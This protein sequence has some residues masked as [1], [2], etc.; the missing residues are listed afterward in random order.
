MIQSVVKSVV[1][2]VV[3]KSGSRYWTQQ[4][5]ILRSGVYWYRREINRIAGTFVLYYS[6]DSGATWDT[7]MTLD[8]TEDSVIIDLTHI[9]RH[10]IVG[11]QYRVD[12]KLTA[13]GYAGVED[14]DW[15]NIYST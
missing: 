11:T 3:D 15:E 14:T 13:L 7:L 10:R 2:D 9:Y 5:Y 4:Y 1:R 6:N 12:Q 8:L